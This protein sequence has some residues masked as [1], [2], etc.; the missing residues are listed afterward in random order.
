MKSKI[1]AVLICLILILSSCNTV[2]DIP[3]YIPDNNETTSPGTT[4]ALPTDTATN[5]TE[6][7]LDT[8]SPVDTLPKQTKEPT[9]TPSV[10]DKPTPTPT[11]TPKPTEDN[12][13]HYSSEVPESAPVGA[14]YFDDAAFIGDSVTMRLQIHALANKSALGNANFFTIGNF[15]A[16]DALKPVATDSIHPSYQGKKMTAEDC[17]AACGA[18][19]V[20]IMLGMNDISDFRG[21]TDVAIDRYTTLIKRILEKNPGVIIYVQSM[22]PTLAVSTVHVKGITNERIKEYNSKIVKMCQENEWNFVNVATVMY[23]STGNVLKTE[24]CSDPDGMALHLNDSAAKV[25]VQ[26]LKT[27]TVAK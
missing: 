12:N 15:S 9:P 23:E 18:K 16:Y 26:Y 20:Y 22:T 6:V 2:S 13:L 10:T 25:W 27:H 7:P 14:S 5:K 21:G 24:Y 8:T 11:P 3:S 1:F 19:K 4:E 17:V